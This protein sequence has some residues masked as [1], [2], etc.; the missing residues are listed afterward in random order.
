MTPRPSPSFVRRR[1]ESLAA[2][3]ITPGDTVKLAVIAGPADGLDHSVIFEIWEP[4]G[5]QP[6]NTH[7]E[8]TETF[9][10]LRGV[11]RAESDGE[12]TDVGAGDL[13]VLPPRTLHRIVNTG[14]GRL[15]AITTMLPDAGFAELIQ[16]GTPAVL[17]PEDLAVLG[18]EDPAG[19]VL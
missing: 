7:P 16:S 11:G 5:A 10:F 18:T 8:S 4:G 6:F 15:Y 13:L 14:A 12:V 3:H 2:W 1:A 9:F 19:P 17:D